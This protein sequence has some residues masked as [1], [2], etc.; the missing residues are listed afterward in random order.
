[1]FLGRAGWAVSPGIVV[2][3]DVTGWQRGV[4]RANE[5]TVWQMVSTQYYPDPRAGLYFDA[6][7]GRAVDAFHVDGYPYLYPPVVDAVTHSLGLSF[8]IGY[9][10]SPRSF[11]SMTPSL[12]VLYAVPQ[13]TTNTPGGARLGTTLISAG[14]ELAW[15]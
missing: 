6:G 1:M 5:S 9:K 2:N 11:F 13:R 12:T 8:G 15:R 4:G 14:V 3:A 7:V 10:D